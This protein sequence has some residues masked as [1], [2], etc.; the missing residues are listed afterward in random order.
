MLFCCCVV[1]VVLC[2]VLFCSLLVCS[3]YCVLCVDLSAALS[4]ILSVTLCVKLSAALSATMS[5]AT[6]CSGKTPPP[7]LPDSS[8]PDHGCQVPGC[9]QEFKNKGSLKRHRKRFK[10]SCLKDMTYAEYKLLRPV[11]GNQKEVTVQKSCDKT[12]SKRTVFKH[13]EDCHPEML[14]ES[15]EC[16]HQGC[17]QT[18]DTA[19]G[20][21]AV[22]SFNVAWSRKAVE[23]GQ[24]KHVAAEASAPDEGHAGGAPE[25]SEVEQ[26]VDE[27]GVANPLPN[28]DDAEP[29]NNDPGDT[30]VEQQGL[31]WALPAHMGKFMPAPLQ[32]MLCQ[33]SCK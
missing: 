6:H 31:I 15:W 13:L 27:S 7:S 2:A 23:Q 12:M 20:P 25:E 11:G 17:L 1:L 16:G 4:A 9:Q 28:P 24:D 14:Q 26:P 32:N 18:S 5:V 29:P 10:G 30:E 8:F 22:S 3:C 19:Q 33:V 21:D